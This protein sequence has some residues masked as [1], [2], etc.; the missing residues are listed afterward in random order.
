MLMALL[1]TTLTQ[2]CPPSSTHLQ[3]HAPACART[4]LLMGLQQ[5]PNPLAKQTECYTLKGEGKIFGE[6]CFLFW[7]PG[8]NS[9]F[10]PTTQQSCRGA[11]VH[12]PWTVH[13]GAGPC[14]V[15]VTLMSPATQS[16]PHSWQKN[17]L[18][19]SVSF[20]I[21]NN[22]DMFLHFTQLTTFFFNA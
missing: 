21:N 20:H 11:H 7:K 3:R 5:N 9:V 15:S 13:S 22:N 6:W 14:Q 1:R 18:G 10:P 17:L 2:S 16:Q 19:A 4:R 12:P 8:S